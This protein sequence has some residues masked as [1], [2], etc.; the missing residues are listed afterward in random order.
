MDFD[1][2]ASDAA[3]RADARR[4][5]EDHAPPPGDDD[6]SMFVVGEEQEHA[7]V[8]RGRAW[9][10]VKYDHGWAGI[11]WPKEYGGAGG[12]A[13]QEGIF[14]EEEERYG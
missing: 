12:T 13:I 6:H 3:F 8:E 7:F 5:L 1:E 10:R 4:F 14:Q 11:D 2:S 9:Q